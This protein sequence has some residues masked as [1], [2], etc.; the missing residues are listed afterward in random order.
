MKLAIRVGESL[1]SCMLDGFEVETWIG[2][3]LVDILVLGSGVIDLNVN[4]FVRLS[5]NSNVS[6]YPCI[7][8]WPSNYYPI[9]KNLSDAMALN[10]WNQGASGLYLF[11][12]FLHEPTSEESSSHMINSIKY[13]GKKEQVF[14]NFI[15]LCF[16]ADR[17]KSTRSYPNNWLNSKLPFTLSVNNDLALDIPIYHNVNRYNKV[18]L[19]VNISNEKIKDLS[20]SLNGSE[21]KGVDLKMDNIS[22]DLPADQL[23]Y[24]QNTVRLHTSDENETIVQS[25]EVHI[26]RYNNFSDSD[27]TYVV[28]NN[29]FFNECIGYFYQSDK[30]WIFSYNYGWLYPA[31]PSFSTCW[32]YSIEYGWFFLHQDSFDGHGRFYIFS[33]KSWVNLKH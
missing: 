24:G 12:W 21:F 29:W 17:G 15:E 18:S 3:N 1:E 25:L 4:E 9:P 16:A 5:E 11:N 22:L 14:E 31:L 20:V 32:F 23:L 27:R 13:L 26:S 7:Y 6:I 10:Y 19:N 30:S 33:T 28:G 8:G 2:E